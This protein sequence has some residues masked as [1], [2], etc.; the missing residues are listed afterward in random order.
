MNERDIFIAA[1]QKTDAAE[2]RGYLD[3]ACGT[4]VALRQQVE[5]LLQ[6][7]E[8][9]GSFLESPAQTSLATT[10]SPVREGPGTVIGPY[11]LLQQIGEGGMGTVFMAEQTQPVQR[12]V[13]LKLIKSGMD[14]RLVIARFEAERQALALMDHPNIARVLDA[15]TTE[16]GSPYFVMELV[17][18]VP[19]TR[20]C[21]EHHLTPRERLELF[22]PVCL[23]IQHAH[24]KGIIHRDMKPSNVM[25]CIYDGKPVPKVIDFG[26][27]KATGPRLTDRTLFTEFGAIVGT[28]EYM[29][30]EQ[31][32]LDQLDVDT[33]SDV[34]SLGVLLYELLTG[35]TPLERK[36]MK[37]VAILELLRLVR[38]QEAPRPSVRLSTT[39]G[40]PSIAANRGT[41]PK[42]LSGLVRGE[43]DWIVMKCLE[44][45]RNR[46]YETANAFAADVLHYLHGEAVQACPASPRYRFPKFAR[47][48]KLGLTIAGMMAAAMLVGVTS[49][50]VSTVLASR[51]YQAERAAH[52][53]AEANFQRARGAVDEFFTTVSQN[54]LFDVPGL[55]PLRKELL[56]AAAR[57]YRALADERVEDPGVRAGLAVAHLRLAEVYYEVGLFN[58]VFAAID[59]GL[60]LVE[61]LTQEH[62]G[63]QD[64][65]RQLAGFWKGNRRMS[66]SALG[67]V[68]LAPGERTLTRFLVDWQRLADENSQV[69]GFQSDLA[70]M[71]DR[72]AEL[73]ANLPG[74][75]ADA[76]LAGRK[77]MATW[78]KLVLAYPE[79][80]EYLAS[81]G[82]QYDFQAY[83][84]RVS[85]QRQ[86]ESEYAEKAIG[87]FEKLTSAR[88]NV[89]AYREGRASGVSRKA[90]RLLD[91]GNKE[92]AEK[93]YRLA[94]E[95]WEKLTAEHSNV[96]SYKE[97]AAVA[98]EGLGG[99]I[100]TSGRP[101]E[102]LKFFRRAVEMKEK[103]L[104]EASSSSIVAIHFWDTLDRLVKCLRSLGQ[105]EE[106]DKAYS[107]G[108]ITI[109]TH[110]RDYPSVP[111]R[112]ALG[113]FIRLYGFY[114][115]KQPAQA[116]PIFR[117]A[118]LVFEKLTVEEPRNAQNR[119]FLADTH[120]IL[121]RLLAATHRS[122][123]AEKAYRRA[124]E[125]HDKRVA[126]LPGQAVDEALVT[127]SNLA[128]GEL[129]AGAGREEEAKQI[130]QKLVD[131]RPKNTAALNNLSWLLATCADPKLRDDKR[132]VELAN[133]AVEL[134]PKQG[135]WRN[136]LGAAQYRA[137][138]WKDS[139]ASLEKSL[140][141]RAGGDS[142]DFF[143]LA[144]A[145][146]QLGNKDQAHKR[147]DQAVVWMDKNQPKNL[148]LLRLRT[149]AADLFKPEMGVGDQKP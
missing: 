90:K 10:D 125:V 7:H 33:R 9:A 14:S 65:L 123:E 40:L 108:M 136:T 85:G 107:H 142:F 77:A 2:R 39:E 55:Q 118:M 79:E 3:A 129:L 80:P 5:S 12:K 62:P 1:L 75:R 116:E 63:D 8:E 57:Y 38:E 130:Y 135:M 132:A 36:R 74:R 137:G 32:E 37:E 106:A 43:L 111:T 20:Y 35:T 73:Q 98:L 94:V 103:A 112:W 86:Q 19:I 46:R 67:T 17:K 22:V 99:Q 72:I 68:D 143:F 58:E 141:L 71:Y 4:D 89:I 97:Q 42:R 128:L 120:R 51:A 96:S 105:L 131:M 138:N 66:N 121:G 56:E 60:D 101:Q 110:V 117:K 31:A 113:H 61:P 144:M 83:L 13:A 87:I 6:I 92:E 34:Y 133:K 81:L 147:F 88:P 149:E 26:V 54:K 102:A 126:E 139:I 148:E 134:E 45:D 100:E 124:I 27:A 109:E 44:K 30:P 47:R 59:A 69:P 78:E 114:L 95:S 48:H 127:G 41:E 64:L 28:F 49:L 119:V 82:Q 24:H 23:A 91:G 76:A 84:C 115:W 15:G 146:W 29:S 70:T 25:V 16:S 53:Q 11:K 18:G 145:H 93:Y 52:Q 140:E 104:A 50:T 122:D 21:D